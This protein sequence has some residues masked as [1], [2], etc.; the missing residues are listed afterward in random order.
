MLFSEGVSFSFC[1]V[2]PCSRTTSRSLRAGSRPS[3][4]RG[5][6]RPRRLHNKAEKS[7]TLRPASR[8]S[9]RGRAPRTREQVFGPGRGRVCEVETLADF[10]AEP[11]TGESEAE[12]S[13]TLRPASR[14]S[15]RGRARRTREQV[16]GP[17]RGRVCE[18]EPLRLRS[19]AEKSRTLRP[20]SRREA[21][22]SR[23]L[24][25]GTRC[26]HQ[27]DV[28]SLRPA[29]RRGSRGGA[30]R[31][32]ALLGADVL[33]LDERQD[34]LNRLEIG[35]R[36]LVHD[37]LEVSVVVDQLDHVELVRL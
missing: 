31:T 26:R 34:R 8:R 21:E 17:G 29:S 36:A 3:L 18:V 32:R 19:E 25:P 2:A 10:V 24:R 37:R 4:R 33:A 5:R 28:A 35:G 12:K 13:R 30:L 23:T 15:S 11:S 20:A 1:T 16:F 14:R 22:K 7:R 6:L 27:P 9:S